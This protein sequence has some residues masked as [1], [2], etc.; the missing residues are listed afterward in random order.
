MLPPVCEA[1]GMPSPSV[2]GWMHSSLKRL[3]ALGSNEFAVATIYAG[4]EALRKLVDGT[5][6]YLLPLKGARADRYNSHLEPLWKWV[7]E[8][9][10]PDVVHIHGSEYPHGL[11]FV[12]ACGADGTIVSLQGIISS[13]ARYYTA[14]IDNSDIKN[15]FS[16]RD[17]LRGGGINAGKRSFERRGRDEISL[18]QSVKHIA[19]RTE[20]DK[21]H[22]L[23]INPKAAYHYSGE[24][25]RDSFYNHRWQYSECRPHSIFVS[26]AGYPIKGLHKLLEA[27]PLILAKYPDVRI[28]VAGGD[29]TSL[30]WWRITDYGIYLRRLIRRLGLQGKV[31]FT[32]SLT[33]AEMCAEY[34]RANVF[35]CCSSIENSPNSL[36]EAQML[37][38]PHVASF[39]GGVPEIVKY[40]SEVL[41][42][43][44]ETEQLAAAVC[45]IFA[46]ADAAVAGAFD[47]S[48]YDGDKNTRDLLSIYLSIVGN[49]SQ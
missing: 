18:L 41:Y 31:E 42:R 2:G 48:R 25:L 45:R 6:Y 12:R 28:R 23:A 16:L 11:A 35:V 38:V 10:A 40:N 44:E 22:A 7:K 9:F 4:H 26:Q 5:V 33:E 46:A 8:D 27:M 1:M 43:F 30:P 32:G 36:G 20:W 15:C 21:A 37:G 49:E 47:A 3:Q 34:L 17:L 39:V 29:V 14:C 13:I 19:G 24:T